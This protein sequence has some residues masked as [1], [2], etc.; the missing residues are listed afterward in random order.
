[1]R[2][3]ECW[4]TLDGKRWCICCVTTELQDHEES[5]CPSCIED[6][7]KSEEPDDDFDEEQ[8]PM[9]ASELDDYGF[10]MNEHNK[11]CTWKIPQAQWHEVQKLKEEN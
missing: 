9:C 10:C 2:K 7:Q 1:M 6:L 4:H 8:C 3:D 11:N 5:Y